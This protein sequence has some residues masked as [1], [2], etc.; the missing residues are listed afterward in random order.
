M[1]CVVKR[2]L[3]LALGM[4]IALTPTHA[5]SQDGSPSA[6]L[7]DEQPPE[8]TGVHIQP[9]S[10][11]MEQSGYSYGAPAASTDT[12]TTSGSIVLCT[13][14]SD[15]PYSNGFEIVGAGEQSC[16]GTVDQWVQVCLDRDSWRGWIQLGCTDTVDDFYYTDYLDWVITGCQP[17]TYNYRIRTRGGFFDVDGAYYSSPFV[18]SSSSRESC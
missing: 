11:E 9:P 14:Y 16:T 5:L 6:L 13:I 2:S 3:V 15:T 8:E 18:V 17:G 12:P 4:L 7:T 10:S 1:K